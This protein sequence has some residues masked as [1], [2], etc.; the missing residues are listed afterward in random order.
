MNCS[1]Y[2]SEILS[3]ATLVITQWIHEQSGHGGKDEC[4]VSAQQH[5]LPLTKASLAMASA[6]CPICQQERPKLNL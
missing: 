2:T 6:A 3:P 4:Y 1:V 5:G